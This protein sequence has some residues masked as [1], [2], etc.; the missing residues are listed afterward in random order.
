MAQGPDLSRAQY[1]MILKL[2]ESKQVK[3]GDPAK[4]AEW[5][6]IEKRLLDFLSGPGFNFEDNNPKNN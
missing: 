2:V 5:Q 1:Q 4:F 3:V 6:E